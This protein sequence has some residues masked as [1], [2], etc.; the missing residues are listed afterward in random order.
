MRN[1]ARQIFLT[2]L[3]KSNIEAAFARHIDYS[4]RVLRICEDLYHLDSYARVFV[5]AIGKAAHTMAEALTRRIGPAQGIIA[6]PVHE[7]SQLPGFR[8]FHGGHPVPNA[9]SI[10]AARAAL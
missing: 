1:T 8:Y 5:L 9:E 10:A 7:A 3:Q 4:G 2:A 6:C